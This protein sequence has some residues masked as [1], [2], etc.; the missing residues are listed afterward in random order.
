MMPLRYLSAKLKGFFY[1]FT[2]KKIKK[3]R[4]GLSIEIKEKS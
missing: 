1:A 2:I 4:K 3:I